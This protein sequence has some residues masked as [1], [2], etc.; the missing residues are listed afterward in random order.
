M[1]K[2]IKNYKIIQIIQIIFIA[3]ILY[4]LFL[5]YLL[6]NKYK[7]SQKLKFYNIPQTTTVSSTVQPLATTAEPQACSVSPGDLAGMCN[8]YSSCCKKG[9]ASSS[10]LCT[11]PVIQKCQTK[12]NTCMTDSNYIKKYTPS[13]L[14]DT[15]SAINS[16]CCNAYNN[17]NIDSKNF[18]TPIIKTQK[19][20]LICYIPASNNMNMT[21]KCMELCETNPNC[22][23]FS[24]NQNNMAVFG[25][26][27]FSKVS[28]TNQNNKD[29][30]I[31][32]LPNYYIKK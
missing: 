10:C 25:C 14:A 22:A 12:Y 29:S 30:I 4:L 17:I 3:I 19:D 1:F 28:N 2:N 13:Q 26:N 6:Y 31:E 5:L 15:C 16:E 9:N 23:A 27:L 20:N 18:N 7:N 32:Q 21:D 11:H 24:I 8:N